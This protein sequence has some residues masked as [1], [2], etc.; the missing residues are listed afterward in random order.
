M[1]EKRQLKCKGEFD[2]DFVNDILFFKVKN[3]EYEKSLEFDN[4]VIDLDEEGFIVGLQIFDASEY[5]RIK[6]LYLR[7]AVKWRFEARLEKIS[8]LKS[9]LE[10]RLMFQ[11][12]IRNKIVQPEPIITQDV[13]G[14]HEDSRILCEPI[15]VRN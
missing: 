14:A 1:K 10:I 11:V 12:S 15:A 6:K 7:A 3:R 8:K 9:R 5:F 2:Y 4:L 13:R